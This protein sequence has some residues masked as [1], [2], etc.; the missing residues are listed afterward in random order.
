MTRT[1]RPRSG[2]CKATVFWNSNVGT[3][4]HHIDIPMSRQVNVTN[5]VSL[6]Y[7]YTIASPIL[8]PLILEATSLI[9]TANPF[10]VSVREVSDQACC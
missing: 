2:D 3:S 7:E 6:K 4:I 5:L 9:A 8:N 1:I 10:F